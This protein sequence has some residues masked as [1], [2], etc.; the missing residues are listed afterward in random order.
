M[1]TMMVA[2]PIDWDKQGNYLS[3]KNK[4]KMLFELQNEMFFLNVS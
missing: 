1:P 3:N 2:V 4:T